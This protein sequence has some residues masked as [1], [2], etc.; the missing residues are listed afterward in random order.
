MDLVSGDSNP[1]VI[2]SEAKNLSSIYVQAMNQSAILRFAQNDN[3]RTFSATLVLGAIEI[4][5]ITAVQFPAPCRYGLAA[6]V[7]SAAFTSHTLLPR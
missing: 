3:V 5:A 4:R 6:G 7:S 2:L 1:I